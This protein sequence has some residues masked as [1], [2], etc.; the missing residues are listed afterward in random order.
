MD[1]EITLG[2]LIAKY[3]KNGDG[4]TAVQVADS[5]EQRQFRP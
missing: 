2:M 1:P 5:Q 4:T 3:E